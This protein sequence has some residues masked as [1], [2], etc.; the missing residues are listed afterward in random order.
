LTNLTKGSTLVSLY[1]ASEALYEQFDK[2][3][4]IDAGKMIYFGPT[5][6]AVA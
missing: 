1:Q 2:V 6:K 5:E 4:L 3:M